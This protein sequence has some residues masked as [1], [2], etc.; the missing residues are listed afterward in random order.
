MAVL[1]IQQIIDKKAGFEEKRSKV[2][3]LK[4][5]GFGDVKYKMASRTEIIS[6]QDLD[7]FDVDPYLIFTHVVEPNLA[8]KGLQEAYNMVGLEPHKI[9][10]K[11][12][13]TDDVV[14]LSLAIVGRNR[15]DITKDL[16]N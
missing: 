16:K 9:V 5:K 6:A 13:E 8:D 7:K 10:D 11:L 1:T 14:N 4:V 12:F 15:G 2:Y 3:T